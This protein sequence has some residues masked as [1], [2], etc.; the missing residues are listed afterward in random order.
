MPD[1]E[2]HNDQGGGESEH[3]DND[4]NDQPATWHLLQ[5]NSEG[6]CN[7]QQHTDV[8]HLGKGVKECPKEREN[9]NK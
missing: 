2:K 8:V 4:L 7:D 9:R 3:W 5:K 6:N 1:L